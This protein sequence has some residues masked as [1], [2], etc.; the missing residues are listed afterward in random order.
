MA[1]LRQNLRGFKLP[2]KAF[3][4]RQL[5]I[6]LF[7]LTLSLLVC[8]STVPSYSQTPTPTL[9]PT[10]PTEKLKNEIQQQAEYDVED[11]IPRKQT[12]ELVDLYGK[13][14]VGIE[15]KTIKR[16][17]DDEY[18]KRSEA[19]KKDLR[20]LLKPENGWLAAIVLFIVLI[21]KDTLTKW[22]SSFFEAVGNQ[23]IGKL[24]GIP[25]LQ[26]FALKRYKE[27]L[28]HKYEKLKISFRPDRP[29]NLKDIYVPL[30]VTGGSDRELIDAFQAITKHR[31]LMVKGSPGSG[32][33]MLLKHIALCYA[34]GRWSTVF[35]KFQ[36]I[37][38]LLELHRLSSSEKTIEEHLEDA[39]DR[40]GFKNAKHFV[41][42]SLDKGRLL[43][44]FDGLDEVNSDSRERVV[45]EIKNLLDKHLKCP[46]IITC[47]TAVYRDEFHEVVER[48][49]EVAEFND[50]QIRDFLVPWQADMPEGKS[51]EQLIQ[52]LHDRPR[53]M[54]MARNPLMLTIIAYLYADTPVVLPRS[55]AEFYRKA[56]DILLEQWHEERNQFEARV[57]KLILPNLALFF[58]DNA[59][60]Q[61]QDRRSVDWIT[62]ESEVRRILPDLNLQPETDT[63]PILKEIVERSGLLLAIDGGDRYQF[64]H[65]TLQ[66]FFAAS[67]LRDDADGLIRRFNADPDAW[68]ETL[69]LWCGLAGDS[70]NLIR[71]VSTRFPV[72]AF[73]CLADAQKVDS[74]LADEIINSFKSRLG[75]D[76]NEDIVN[77]AFASVAADD[78]RRTDVF[79]FLKETLENTSET[80]ACRKAALNALSLTNLPSAAKLLTKQY[81]NLDNIEFRLIL[82]QALIRMGDIAVSEIKNAV[83]NDSINQV[84]D[85]LVGIAT[86]SALQALVNWLWDKDENRALRAAL[87]LASLIKQEKH[88]TMLN[89]CQLLQRYSRQDSFDWIVE[90]YGVEPNLRLILQQIVYCISKKLTDSVEVIDQLYIRDFDQKLIIPICFIQALENPEFKDSLK[91]PDKADFIRHGNYENYIQN[92]CGLN[93]PTIWGFLIYNIFPVYFSLLKRTKSLTGKELKIKWKGEKQN[94]TLETI[95]Y[96]L[97]DTIIKIDTINIESRYYFLVKIKNIILYFYKLSRMI[98]IWIK[99]KREKIGRF[100]MW[101]MIHIWIKKKREKIG[102]FWM[103]RMIYIWIKKKR[104]KIGRFW[105]WRMI[106]IGIKK[107]YFRFESEMES[108]WERILMMM[109]IKGKNGYERDVKDVKSDLDLILKKLESEEKNKLAEYQL[110]W[111]GKIIINKRLARPH[112]N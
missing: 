84:M 65:L 21:F 28:K 89:A 79:T 19:K 77:H 49:L 83:T 80:D 100:W 50:Q 18:K 109:V 29:L 14:A 53:I 38:I 6:L 24:S 47:R 5:Y 13:E 64:A 30:K 101:R 78:R 70:T 97:I 23:I 96:T 16:I 45:N 35:D 54:D 40:D 37:P 102:R 110:N 58:Q 72:V 86:K 87:L 61:G 111:Q 52:T 68:R 75:E 104:E 95:F 34:D 106:H 67:Q 55:R 57:K 27:E 39:F 99:K 76:G 94:K 15:P 98:H 7:T 25:L 22:V 9:T 73:E 3:K 112:K 26:G 81:V 108:E 56:T 12:R 8:I 43:L 46:V 107:F 33:T 88:K 11:D 90:P 62:V 36:C 20:E 91:N 85:A 31:R 92:L 17:Y 51:V 1:R 10:A 63:K 69:K 103:W 32:K 41:S 82:D 74:T 48:T 66:E 93:E 59:N 71:E 105:M 42:E 44:L 60:Q 4:N 2:R